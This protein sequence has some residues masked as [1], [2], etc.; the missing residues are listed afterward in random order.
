M[1]SYSVIIP[2]YR[3]DIESQEDL[4]EE[5]IR[6]Y[7][8]DNLPSSLLSFQ[9]KK[10]IINKNQVCRELIRQKL[11]NRGYQEI[12]TYSLVSQ[13]IKNDFSPP[14]ENDFYWLSTP[15]SESHV[16]YRQSL[17]PSHLKTI[18]YNLNH[19]NENLFFFEISKIYS[20]SESE[21]EILTL[22]GTGK[23]ITNSVHKLEQEYDFFWLKGII[24]EIFH[25][26]NIIDK[27]NFVPSQIKELHSYQSADIFLEQEK[28]GFL[29]KIHP[30]LSKKHQLKQPVFGAQISLS[31]LFS[32][33]AKTK[34]RNYQIISPFPKI[35]QDLSLILEENILVGEV[36]K[37]IKKNDFPW[38][39][40]IKVFDAYQSKED[41]AKRQK[42]L[43]FRL[44][45][46]SQERTLRKSE[47]A[48]IV[49]KI[50]LQL[51]TSLNAK[52][53]T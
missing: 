30:Q 14:K 15:K 11:V 41:K 24:K 40:N 53:K 33:L 1:Y 46:Q 34:Q 27:V 8:Y 23:I 25:I 44:I 47:I 9:Q 21:E 45:F 38:L 7:G 52:L 20:P 3:L 43:T 19:Q 13:E 17:L 28:T 10:L 22:S 6:I 48:E 26:L 4:V 39:K 37:I 16:Y 42:S 12:I 18:T 35:E 32:F 29:G 49:K 36:T 2:S 31:K 51:E 5:I 50:I